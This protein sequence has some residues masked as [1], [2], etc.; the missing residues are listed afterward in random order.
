MDSD[1]ST[2]EKGILDNEQEAKDAGADF[3]GMSELIAKVQ[4]RYHFILCSLEFWF[5]VTNEWTS[6]LLLN[7]NEKNN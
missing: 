2:L 1:R 4:E 5:Q 3:A 6:S 7:S